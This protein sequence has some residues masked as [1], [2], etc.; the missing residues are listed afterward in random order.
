MPGDT[1]RTT[2]AYSKSFSI[3]HINA[4]RLTRPANFALIKAH[5]NSHQLEPTAII[6][7]FFQPLLSDNTLSIDAYNLYRNDRTGKEDGGVDLYVQAS[8][9]V[10]A[11]SASDPKFYNT[12]EFIVAEINKANTKLLIS[13]VNRRPYALS[14]Y[15]LFEILSAFIPLYQHM[16]V[17]SYH[18]V[19]PKLSFSKI[20]STPTPFS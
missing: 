9:I 19:S 18:L 11:L 10:R 7:T 13:C 2:Q 5:I 3:G 4:N 14:A 12:P 20:P 6:T 8:W 17:T 1:P 16:I 15:S